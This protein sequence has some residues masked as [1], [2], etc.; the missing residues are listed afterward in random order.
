MENMIKQ[1]RSMHNIKAKFGSSK[2][3]GK[4]PKKKKIERKSRRKEKTKKKKI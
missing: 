3:W 2:I 1:T 4:M